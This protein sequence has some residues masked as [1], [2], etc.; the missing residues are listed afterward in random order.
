MSICSKSPMKVLRVALELGN[1]VLP[2]YAHRFSPKKFTQAQL[3]G[4]LV[5]K[6]FFG[7]DY[8]GIE[9]ILRDSPNMRDA[10]GIKRVPHFTTLQKAERRILSNK[11]VA[12][13]L[14]ESIF[15]DAREKA[16]N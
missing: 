4:C 16:K 2:D 9:G 14:E 12:R 13:M 3:F 11:H 15:F 7:T 10:L 5:L 6:M 8:R 1:R